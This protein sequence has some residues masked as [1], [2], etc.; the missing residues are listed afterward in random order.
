MRLIIFLSH[1]LGCSGGTQEALQHAEKQVQDRPASDST[2]WYQTVAPELSSALASAGRMRGELRDW[3]GIVQ[4]DCAWLSDAQDPL[5]RDGP[6]GRCP[7]Q[8]FAR[9]ADGWSLV[10]S[11]TARDDEGRSAWLAAS[12]CRREL[13]GE[14]DW[15]PLEQH[16]GALGQGLP[17]PEC[18]VLCPQDVP[19]WKQWEEQEARL[20]S[21]REPLQATLTTLGVSADLQLHASLLVGDRC[22]WMVDTRRPGC[23]GALSTDCT[24]T[25]FEVDRDQIMLRG[26]VPMEATCRAEASC[27][28]QR[29]PPAPA[30]PPN[31]HPAVT[32][33]QFGHQLHPRS[34]T[35]AAPLGWTWDFCTPLEASSIAPEDGPPPATP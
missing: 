30:W 18:G 10:Q 17:L 19:A 12:V 31:P 4:G 26:M 28:P 13:T 14:G 20:E 25:V 8:I 16:L 6:Q 9:S 11:T 3:I 29:V 24:A 1:L 34:A 22:L 21:M 27:R 32:T 7:V 35:D 5:C 23:S 2:Q 15:R 33:E